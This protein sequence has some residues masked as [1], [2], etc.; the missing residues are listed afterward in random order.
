M[1]GKFKKGDI[2]VM[3]R[4]CYGRKKECTLKELVGNAQVELN[5]S[6]CNSCYGKKRKRILIKYK[7]KFGNAPWICQHL[8]RPATD[9]EKLLYHIFGGEALKV[10]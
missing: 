8:I 4:T 7:G 6:E 10:K 5:L 3:Y 1:A 2:V 9:R